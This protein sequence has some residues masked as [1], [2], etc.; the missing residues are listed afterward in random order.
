[1]EGTIF[2]RGAALRRCSGEIR[3]LETIVWV[4]EPEKMSLRLRRAEERAEERSD[5]L[6]QK[7][8]NIHIHS[9]IRS[10]HSPEGE[11]VQVGGVLG[12]VHHVEAEWSGRVG[13]E[14]GVG[15]GG[16]WGFERDFLAFGGAGAVV[17]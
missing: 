9:S 16:G 8:Y 1:M 6:V 3:K 11:F 15:G 12:A 10:S 17:N 7:I 4:M 5:E 14:G 13:L 2:K